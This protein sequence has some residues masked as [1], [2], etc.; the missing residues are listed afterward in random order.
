[1]HKQ[2]YVKNKYIFSVILILII[3]YAL[4]LYGSWYPHFIDDDTDFIFLANN[5]S[6]NLN[7][8]VLIPFGAGH[9]PLTAY[10][11]KMS[12]L[13]FGENAF[14]WRISSVIC[15][16]LINLIIFFWPKKDLEGKKQFLLRR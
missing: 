13:I 4:R 6:L 3:G 7:N 1:M 8:L 12:G 16:I 10:L 5:I 9:G 14:G 11:I 2:Q 15:G